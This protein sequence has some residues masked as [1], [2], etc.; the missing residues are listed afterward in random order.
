MREETR[1]V[2]SRKRK[3]EEEEEEMHLFSSEDEKM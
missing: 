3:G 1:R 2:R